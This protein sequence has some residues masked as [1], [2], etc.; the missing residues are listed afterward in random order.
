MPR[1]CPAP[2]GL[3]GPPRPAHGGLPALLRP[4]DRRLRVLRRWAAAV[5]CALLAG[6]AAQVS[7]QIPTDLSF[8][9]LAGEGLNDRD[10]RVQRYGLTSSRLSDNDRQGSL[11]LVWETHDGGV[12]FARL[13]QRVAEQD[14]SLRYESLQVEL[15]RYFPIGGRGRYYWGFRG[16]YSRIIGHVRDPDTG[17]E[18]VVEA[19]QIAPLAVLAVPLALENMGFLLVGLIEGG[20]VGVVIDIVERKLWLDFQ[21]GGALLPRFRN[22]LLVLDRPY[23]L[24]GTLQLAWVF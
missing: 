15:K 2:N 17:R 23:A 5:L 18:R 22:E 19:A 12:D 6:G 3:P 24:A 10:A 16:G 11:A 13:D 7:A 9:L 20:S 21:L 1:A 14:V 4:W 8:G